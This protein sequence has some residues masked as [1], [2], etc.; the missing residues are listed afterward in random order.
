LGGLETGHGWVKEGESHTAEGVAYTL[1]LLG[2]ILGLFDPAQL[3]ERKF[4]LGTEAQNIMDKLDDALTRELSD[5]PPIDLDGALASGGSH[6]DSD[7]ISQ[8]SKTKQQAFEVFGLGDADAGAVEWPPVELADEYMGATDF[9]AAALRVSAIDIRT[10]T[11]FG[12]MLQVLAAMAT[13]NITDFNPSALFRGRFSGQYGEDDSGSPLAPLDAVSDEHGDSPRSSSQRHARDHLLQKLIGCNDLD[14][15]LL[16]ASLF[17][18]D[19]EKVRLQWVLRA[20]EM[21]NEGG[22]EQEVIDAIDDR[23]KLGVGLLTVARQR[24]ARVLLAAQDRVEEQAAHERM[25]AD[26]G[27]GAG[28]PPI[29]PR[30]EKMENDLLR[31]MQSKLAQKQVRACNALCIPWLV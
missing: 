24:L 18:H 26:G 1:V 8:A 21:G 31:L 22:L 30:L 5:A 29:V 15:A 12:V 7:S 13:H 14:R 11:E 17:G 19:C 2:R 6:A 23:Y 4:S 25:A 16:V 9:S 20:Y 27:N 3:L 28:H 10:H